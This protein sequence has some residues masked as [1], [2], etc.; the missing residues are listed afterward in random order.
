MHGGIPRHKLE[1]SH[2]DLLTQERLFL[3]TVP[4]HVFH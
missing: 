4:K 1:Q 2:R 3:A